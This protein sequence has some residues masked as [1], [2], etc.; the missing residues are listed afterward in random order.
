RSR[1]VETMSSWCLTFFLAAASEPAV[2]TVSPPAWLVAPTANADNLVTCP[3][4]TF[5]HS[6]N[7][8]AI[9]LFGD[10][11]YVA[12]RSAPHHHPR[13][14]AWA[15]TGARPGAPK[16]F[17]IS[18]PFGPAE[19]ERILRR[20]PDAWKETRWRLEFEAAERLDQEQLRPLRTALGNPDTR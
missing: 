13:P 8:V 15:D 7:N 2:P 9:T 11:L 5:D 12:V 20:W 17:V 18:T 14:P 4:V 16:L 3:G 10:R 1:E 6:N 19:R